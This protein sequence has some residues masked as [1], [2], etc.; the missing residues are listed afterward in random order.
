MARIELR[1]ILNV[2]WQ[3]T[4]SKDI[5]DTLSFLLSMLVRMLSVVFIPLIHFDV[6]Y[7]KTKDNKRAH[8]RTKDFALTFPQ[9]SP[10]VLSF[11]DSYCWKPRR[12]EMK[13]CFHW[14]S[15]EDQTFFS[16]QYFKQKRGMSGGRDFVCFVRMKTSW[17]RVSFEQFSQTLQRAGGGFKCFMCNT[18]RAVHC[19][20]CL[21]DFFKSTRLHFSTN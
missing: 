5:G 14:T 21:K 12:I 15:K 7:K 6:Q 4:F 9:K 1:P 17:S 19:V 3:H 11:T 8:P 13:E 18:M 16:K 10:H 2:F 20:L